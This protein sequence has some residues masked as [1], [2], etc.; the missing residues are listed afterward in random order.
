M[1]ID[2]SRGNQRYGLGHDSFKG[3]ETLVAA[4]M[5]SSRS[6]RASIPLVAGWRSRTGATDLNRES[7]HR[8][9]G[10][11]I[12]WNRQPLFFNHE[13]SISLVQQNTF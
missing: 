11:V 2:F 7:L 3:L 9:S 6:C 12:A 5:S 4:Y 8:N 13:T 10:V 1:Q